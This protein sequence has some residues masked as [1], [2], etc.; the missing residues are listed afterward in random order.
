VATHGAEVAELIVAGLLGLA[1]VIAALGRS[2]ESV[3]ST[4]RAVA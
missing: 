4:G 3:A 2:I 1:P